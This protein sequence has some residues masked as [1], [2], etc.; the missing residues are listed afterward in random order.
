MKYEFQLPEFP[1]SIFEI[2]SSPWTG[3]TTLLKDN[4]VVEQI[5]DKKGKAFLIP[6]NNG[7]F[8][9]AFPR[10]SFPEFAPALEINGTKIEIVK[11]LKWYQ[12]ALAGLPLLLV[13]QGGAIG[14]AIGFVAAHTSFKIF[15][16]EGRN[17]FKYLKVVGIVTITFIIYLLIAAFILELLD[18][19]PE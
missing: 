18:K 16:G 1:G 17:V 3:K 19:S 14:A 4:V 10:L 5:K 9:K 8:V 13:F 11:K 6:T 2:E 12:Y 15:R 7:D